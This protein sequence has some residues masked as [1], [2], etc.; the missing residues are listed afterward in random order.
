MTLEP[1]ELKSPLWAKLREYMQGRIDE[2]RVRNDQNLNDI[3]T[4]KLRGRLFEAKEFLLLETP[5]EP[6]PDH[7]E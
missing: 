5:A 1:H 2:L 6:E 7:I 4:A 3:D